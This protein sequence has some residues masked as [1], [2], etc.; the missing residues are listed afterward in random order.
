MLAIL[1][2]AQCVETEMVTTIGIL[3]TKNIVSSMNPSIFNFHIHFLVFLIDNSSNAEHGNVWGWFTKFS[4][5][6]DHFY[7][8][9]TLYFTC[10]YFDYEF[11]KI[12]KGRN[13]LTAH[14][15]T[16]M[17]II[18]AWGTPLWTQLHGSIMV[19]DDATLS[20]C[21]K[22]IALYCEDSFATYHLLHQWLPEDVYKIIDNTTDDL[23][24][25]SK[26]TETLWSIWLLRPSFPTYWK[27]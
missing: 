15:L 5:R 24:T 25:N 6:S 26:A 2:S 23:T 11:G 19:S 9:Q 8:E 17:L 22:E 7:L 20:P 12:T 10:S 3:H 16:S 14:T 13:G 4:L 18:C 27:V 1:I 21:L